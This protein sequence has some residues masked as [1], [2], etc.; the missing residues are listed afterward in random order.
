MVRCLKKQI[1]SIGHAVKELI[2]VGF[3]IREDCIRHNML[4][5]FKAMPLSIQNDSEA[6][7]ASQPIGDTETRHH[8]FGRRPDATSILRPL[9]TLH[10]YVWAGP[11]SI[12]PLTRITSDIPSL[13]LVLPPWYKLR[14]SAWGLGETTRKLALVV[15]YSGTLLRTPRIASV[16]HHTSR[17]EEEV[18]AHNGSCLCGCNPE[19]V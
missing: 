13:W 16:D 10:R 19:T 6:I 2:Q 7:T 8:P 9:N 15:V 4:V 5:A 3:P 17:P 1:F 18:Y 11:P 12:K 14:R